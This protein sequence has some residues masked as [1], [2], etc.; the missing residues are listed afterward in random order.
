M[1]L[2]HLAD[3]ASAVVRIADVAPVNA[4]A[5]AAV[6]D[7]VAELLGARVIRR[8]PSGDRRAATRQWARDGGADV[9]RAACDQHHTTGVRILVLRVV[10]LAARLPSQR[11]LQVWSYTK[12]IT[13]RRLTVMP[14]PSPAGNSRACQPA[15]IFQLQTGRNRMQLRAGVRCLVRPIR[16]WTLGN[17]EHAIDDRSAGA[18]ANWSQLP[19]R[20]AASRKPSSWRILAASWSMQSRASVLRRRSSSASCSGDQSSS[21]SRRPSSRAAARRCAAG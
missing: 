11:P 13:P 15:G 18:S 1:L 8:V 5:G 6:P 20:Q 21:T 16:A 9:A 4:R 17:C 10:H 12:F 7:R 2:D 14:R 19:P 3:D